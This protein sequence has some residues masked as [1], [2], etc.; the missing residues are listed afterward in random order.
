MIDNTS[1]TPI[2]T[3][4]QFFKWIFETINTE[5]SYAEIGLRLCNLSEANF[6][7]HHYR[8]QDYATNIL[9]FPLNLDQDTNR[10]IGDLIMC[11]AV[12]IK[13]SQEQG[14]ITSHH[15]AHLVVHGVL[16]L[17]GYNHVVEQD[18]NDMEN[19]EINLL[20]SMGYQNPYAT[21]E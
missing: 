4:D 20:Y 12:V 18:T 11:P 8:N 16:H 10:I 1:A 6:Y 15:Y 7:N 13:E 9:S 5:Y 19:K 3:Y 21:I 17:M 14:K 2:P